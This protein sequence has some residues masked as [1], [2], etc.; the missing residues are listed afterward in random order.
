MICYKICSLGILNQISGRWGRQTDDV[1]W[2][3]EISHYRV[4]NQLRSQHL[5]SYLW[6]S[7]LRQINDIAAQEA[8][9]LG[10]RKFHCT[11]KTYRFPTA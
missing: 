3:G 6:C 11:K 7:P 10:P 2:V 4:E 5:I 8:L 1:N 9:N